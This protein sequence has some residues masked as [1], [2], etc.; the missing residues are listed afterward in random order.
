[1]LGRG[2]RLV[3]ALVRADGPAGAGGLPPPVGRT[4][5]ARTVRSLTHHPSRPLRRRLSCQYP[6]MPRRR[7]TMRA[8]LCA[9]LAALAFAAFAFAADEVEPSGG[10]IKDRAG[11]LPRQKHGVL[12]GKAVGVLVS[13]VRA[14]MAQEGRGGPPDAVGFSAGG[15]SYRWIYVPTQ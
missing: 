3:P 8:A 11:Y 15:N 5:A 13:D 9:A 6:H 7:T 10:P 14:V 4:A 1:L 12:K 2:T